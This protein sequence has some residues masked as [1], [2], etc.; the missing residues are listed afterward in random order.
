MSSCIL[1][2]F[3]AN[4][5]YTYSLGLLYR[6]YT[7]LVTNYYLNQWWH[8]LLML[9][10]CSYA[11]HGLRQN[12]QHFPDDIFKCIFMKEN[13]WIPIK[14][15]LKFVPKGPVNN[16]PLLVQIMAWRCPGDKPLSEP[17]N[18]GKFTDVSLSLNKSMVVAL[19]TLLPCISWLSRHLRSVATLL[20]V[21]DVVQWI[22]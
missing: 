20:F 6:L 10:W 22:G 21:Q 19:Q 9:L 14:I 4:R 7:E 13:V 12:R 11:S 18:D 1:L 8:S 17:I 2:W 5:F 15:S 16:I 3:D